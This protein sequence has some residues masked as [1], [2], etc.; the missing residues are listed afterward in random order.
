M[1]IGAKSIVRPTI[2]TNEPI[3]GPYQWANFRIIEKSYNTNIG[4]QAI[5]KT[6][7]G[8]TKIGKTTKTTG[9]GTRYIFL[10]CFEGF[11]GCTTQY[12]NEVIISYG[13]SMLH[14]ITSFI[15]EIWLRM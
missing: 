2:K 6:N 3:I 15:E 14:I 10:W 9:S 13:T 11:K 4:T 12:F 5:S 8:P 1:I 7:E